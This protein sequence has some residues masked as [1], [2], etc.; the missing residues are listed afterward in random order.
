[1]DLQRSYRED[2]R[3]IRKPSGWAAAA[4]GL[5]G[6]AA[7]PFVA[8]GLPGGSYYINVLNLIAINSLVAIGLNILVGYTGQ[9]SLGHAGF[10]ALGAYTQALL[11]T[12]AGLPLPVALPLAGLLAAGF[13]L[14]L[15]LPALRLEGPYLAIATLG[16]GIA[17][18]QIIGRLDFLG[19]RDGLEVPSPAFTE[20]LRGWLATSYGPEHAPD[21]P[22]LAMYLVV[23]PI[24]A[25]MTVAAVNLMKSRVGRAFVAIRDSEIA[26]E[27]IGVNLTA[28]KTAAFAVSAFYTGLAGGLYA[29]A[30]GFIDPPSFD[31]R[32]SILFL[33]MVVVGGLGSVLGSHLGAIL[34]TLLPLSLTSVRNVP[35]IIIGAILILIILFEPLGLRGRWLKLKAYWKSWPF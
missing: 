27:T 25:G 8:L 9:I 10:F 12:Q 22:G 4:L 6:L 19:G 14:L 3:L 1:V 24:C 21:A 15:G 7:F 11:V 29:H 20:H 33:A 23:I 30:M 28:T 13:G 5:A 34:M 31:L 2:L 16:F 26:A 18:T 35:E 32:L 17:V